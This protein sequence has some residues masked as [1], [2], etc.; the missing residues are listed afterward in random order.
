MIVDFKPATEGEGSQS[1]SA[2]ETELTTSGAYPR[3]SPPTVQQSIPWLT[4][5]F[6]N[7]RSTIRL[8]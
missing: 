2:L 5:K 4:T 3:S 1:G 6:Q 8:L 7:I